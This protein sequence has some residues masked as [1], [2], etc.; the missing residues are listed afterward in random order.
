MEP[1][2]Q[3]VML[4]LLLIS[5]CNQ[6]N[7]PKKETSQTT[8]AE[9]VDI[10]NL[11]RRVLQWSDSEHAIRLLPVLTDERDSLYVGFDLALHQKNLETLKKS[12]LFATEFIENYNQIILTLDKGIKS[13]RYEP[14]LVGDLPPFF[15]NNDHSPWCD[16]QDN[17]EWDEV[18]VRPTE[19]KT[20]RAALEWTWGGSSADSLPNWKTFAYKFRAVKVEGKWKVA[21]LQGFDFKQSVKAD[22][23]I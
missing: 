21:Y 20:T 15:F 16:C 4:G 7:P 3:I 19:L 18:V 8:S 5:G 2:K 23:E 11:I 10:Q 1:I 6:P 9:R 14:W 13:G 17:Y 12:G 22:G